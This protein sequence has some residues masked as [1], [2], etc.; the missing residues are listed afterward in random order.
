MRIGKIERVGEREIPMPALTPPAPAVPA[1]P[2]PAPSA[3]VRERVPE[4]TP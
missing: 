2:S 3:P 4:E 1:A